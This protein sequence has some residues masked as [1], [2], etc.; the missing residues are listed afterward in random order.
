MGRGEDAASHDAE[1]RWLNAPVSE[2]IFLRENNLRHLDTTTLSL[3]RSEATVAIPWLEIATSACGLLAMTCDDSSPA[4]RAPTGHVHISGYTCRSPF[5]A[6]CRAEARPTKNI[7]PRCG[8]L[9]IETIPS[10]R[11]R[12]LSA[13]MRPRCGLPR[14]IGVGDY[15]FFEKN[16]LRHQHA[17]SDTCL[18]TRARLFASN[19]VLLYA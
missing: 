10:C 15:F 18:L 7:R 13:K 11:S 4:V 16:N 17:I 1:S 19:D 12:A 8:L 2:I 6:T 14:L 3:R 9:R 5:R